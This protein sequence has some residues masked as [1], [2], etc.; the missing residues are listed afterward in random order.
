[1]RALLVILWLGMAAAAPAQEAVG[2]EG[3]RVVVTGEG[4]VSRAPDRADLR[5]GVVAEA[6][7]AEDAVSALAAR[8]GPVIG[9]LVEAGIAEAAIQTGTLGLAP[10]YAEGPAGPGTGREIAGYRAESLLAVEIGRPEEIGRVVGAA[11]AAGANRLDGIGFRLS[12]PR[13][14]AEEALSR[15]VADAV[16]KAERVAEAAGRTR[17]AVLQIVEQDGGGP[18]QMMMRM[19]AGAADIAVAPGEIEVTATVR[20]SFGLDGP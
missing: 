7:A 4:Q 20:A 16:R 9:A 15:A 14:A 17:G 8:I 6:E 1:M 10:V 13:A 5:L 19:E 11:L 12:D 18:P 3:P 2:T